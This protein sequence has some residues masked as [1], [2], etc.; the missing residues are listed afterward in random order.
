MSKSP[1]IVELRRKHADWTL[2]QIAEKTGV[3]RQAV[4][5]ALVAAGLETRAIAAEVREEPHVRFQCPICTGSNFRDT[6]VPRGSGHYKTAFYECCGC[7]VMFRDPKKF[8]RWA[9]P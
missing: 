5:Q 9:R 6:V 3:S 2:E 4:H 7:G 1:E 8:S